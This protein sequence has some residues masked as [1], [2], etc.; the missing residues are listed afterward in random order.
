MSIYREI[1]IVKRRIRG[2]MKWMERKM[3][4]KTWRGRYTQKKKS[5]YKETEKRGKGEAKERGRKTQKDPDTNFAT[6]EV[7]IF[8][9]EH[10]TWRG[11]KNVLTG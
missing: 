5:I 1:R 9:W 3:N 6:N 7:D 2:K 11:K 4:R 8:T 10:F